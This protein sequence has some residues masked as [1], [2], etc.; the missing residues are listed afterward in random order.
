MNEGRKYP[1]TEGENAIICRSDSCAVFGTNFECDLKIDS[2]SNN[3]TK[4]GCFAN[5]P[6]F[7]LPQAKG[8]G[9]QE[10]SSS[11]NGVKT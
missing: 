11:I 7:N 3:N 9:C 5:R 4:S 10:G 1:I 6:S 8:K 2:D